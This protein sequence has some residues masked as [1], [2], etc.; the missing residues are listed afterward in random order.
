LLALF[1]WEEFK[2]LIL[3]ESCQSPLTVIVNT[4][5]L[6]AKKEKRAAEDEVAG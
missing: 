5:I 2:I 6:V 3:K 4:S 1:I